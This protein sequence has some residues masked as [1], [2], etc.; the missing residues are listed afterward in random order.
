MKTFGLFMC[1]WL[2]AILATLNIW[3]TATNEEL[4]KMV[5]ATQI[6]YIMY[7]LVK[8]EYKS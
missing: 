1:I 4:I 5:M 8:E 7:R 6:A 3:K 2:V